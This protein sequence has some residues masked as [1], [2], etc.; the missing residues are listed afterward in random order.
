MSFWAVFYLFTPLTTHKIKIL[1]KS[2]NHMERWCTKNHDMWFGVWQTYF[3]VILGHFFALSPHYWARKLKIGRNVKKDLRHYPFTHVY[4]KWR[5]YDVWF[6]GYK[7]RQP[8]FFCHFGSF[9]AFDPP[10]KLKNQ[11][12]EKIKKTTWRY[13]HFTLVHYKWQSYDAWLLGY[14]AQ[15]IIFF[16]VILD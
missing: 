15:Q 7:A 8:K 11:N 1:K 10:N 5:S 12:F 14:G 4:H 2:K 13:C 16:F 6:L 9:F 3:F